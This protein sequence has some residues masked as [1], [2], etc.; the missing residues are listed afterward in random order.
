MLKRFCDYLGNGGL[1]FIIVGVLLGLAY[2][3]GWNDANLRCNLANSREV[4]TVAVEKEKISAKVAGQSVAERRK[5]LG[6]YVVK[7]N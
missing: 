3:K 5:G 7:G 1:V 2:Y 4:I 6:K